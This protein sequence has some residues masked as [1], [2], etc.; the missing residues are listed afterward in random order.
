MNTIQ[1]LVEGHGGTSNITFIVPML[2][3]RVVGP[4]AFTSSSDGYIPVEC[5]IVEGD[6]DLY[7]LKGTYKL[8]VEP[9]DPALKPLFGYEKFYQS[10]FMQ[11]IR[12][13]SIKIKILETIA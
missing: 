6:D 5:Q 8:R 13:G 4:I 1:E 3:I 7:S 11:L 10:D 12:D 2:P 9:L